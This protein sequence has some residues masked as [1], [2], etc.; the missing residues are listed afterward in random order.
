MGALLGLLTAAAHP[1]R[2]PASRISQGALVYL[3]SRDIFV[4]ELI[5]D[6]H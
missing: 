5:S 6:L 3:G 2:V 1:S 4:I